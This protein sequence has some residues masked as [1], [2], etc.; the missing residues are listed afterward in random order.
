MIL[1]FSILRQQIGISCLMGGTYSMRFHG[2]LKGAPRSCSI[3]PWLRKR[4][5]VEFS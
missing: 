5:I 2:I 3:A 1:V 4:M